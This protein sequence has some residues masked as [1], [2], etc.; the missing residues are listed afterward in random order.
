M[1][2]VAVQVVT[3]AVIFFLLIGLEIFIDKVIFLVG[4]PDY[5]IISI[6][7]YKSGDIVVGN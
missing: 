6:G 4:I 2:P 3:Y 1:K 7:V 5:P